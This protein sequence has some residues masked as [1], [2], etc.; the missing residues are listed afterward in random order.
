MDERM[1]RDK[2][3]A[4]AARKKYGDL[5]QHPSFR[6]TKANRRRDMTS[7]RA[8]ARVYRKLE[9]LPEVCVFYSGCRCPIMHSEPPTIV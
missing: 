7:D 9:Q 5:A 8:I 2:E 4:D 6:Y 3:Q 1:E